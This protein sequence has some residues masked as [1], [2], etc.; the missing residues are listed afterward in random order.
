M[1]APNHASRA[2]ATWSASSAAR[3]MACA[4]A[5][6]LGATVEEPPESEAAAWGTACHEVAEWAL[7]NGM[8][9]AD[10]PREEVVT[11]AH[12]I[13]VDDEIIETAAEYVAYV[14]GRAETAAWLKV[15]Q[16]FSLDKLNPPLDSGGT[17]DAV[18]YFP[19]EKLLEVVDLKGGR[20]VVVEARG[21]DQ[22]RTY[23]LGALLANSGI[24]VRAVRVTIV[25]PRAPHKDGRIRSEE[26]HAADLIDWTTDLL[27]AM[28]RAVEAQ[29]ALGAGA[30]AI[31]PYLSAG[32]HCK[33]C[34][35]A[36]IC[37]ALRDKALEE[38]GVHFDDLGDA[39]VPN[40]LDSFMPEDIAR[41]LNNADMIQDWLNA[42]RAYAHAQAET[43][44]VIPGYILVAKQGRPK[45]PKAD[46][47]D[48]QMAVMKAA[49]VGIEA[50]SLYAR[51]FKSPAQVRAVLTAA[52]H[53]TGQYTNKKEAEAAAKQL[54]EP[55]LVTESS[56]T[57][58]VAA[59][60]TSRQPVKAKADQ[61][62]SVLD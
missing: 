59:E 30:G 2:H 25:Q 34:K 24:S 29:K 49:P 35:A 6:A 5:L 17:A 12:T 9:C 20:G 36:A 45:W 26:F 51:K 58:L 15:E 18:L 60:K 21:N 31:G 50:D 37:P 3:N 28:G 55:L 40:T 53:D 32:A 16:R 22:L 1:T 23:A 4:G 14:R 57:Q 39:H 27:A 56:G 13:A 8:D 33:F 61:F 43:G 47:A 38:A 10:F 46:E 62:F 44:V 54:L 7:N 52:L 42:V 41:L 19:A 48:L 11:K